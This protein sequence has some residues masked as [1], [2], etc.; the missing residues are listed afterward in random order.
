MPR[1]LLRIAAR[2]G[3]AWSTCPRP[4]GGDP[5]GYRAE[6]AGIKVWRQPAAAGIGRGDRRPPGALP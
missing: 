1:T 5:G 6:D 2:A 3:D 4:T